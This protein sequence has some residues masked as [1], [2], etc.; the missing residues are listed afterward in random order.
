MSNYKQCH[1]GDI[2]ATDPNYVCNPSTGRWIKKNG[3]VHKTLINK[4]IINEDG[5]IIEKTKKSKTKP[6]VP[7]KSIVEKEKST[8]ASKKKTTTVSK[9]KVQSKVNKTGQTMIEKKIK[10]G[11]VDFNFKECAGKQKSNEICDPITGDWIKKCGSKYQSLIEDGIINKKGKI[12]VSKS[13]DQ[14]NIEKISPILESE[15]IENKMSDLVKYTYPIYFTY[16]PLVE[17]KM[18]PSQIN[19]QSIINW[20]QN[21]FVRINLL[22]QTTISIFGDY[23]PKGLNVL[24]KEKIFDSPYKIDY[25]EYIGKIL[26]PVYLQEMENKGIDKESTEGDNLKILVKAA[27]GFLPANRQDYLMILHKLFPQ[28][29]IIKQPDIGNCYYCAIGS[30]LGAEE[31]DVRKD[32]VSILKN[33]DD[34]TYSDFLSDAMKDCP[35]NSNFKKRYLE[36]KSQFAEDYIELMLKSCEKGMIDCYD[37]IWGGNYFDTILSGFYNRPIL[38]IGVGTD[39][40]VEAKTYQLQLGEQFGHS[41]SL[42]QAV[43]KLEMLEEESDVFDDDHSPVSPINDSPVSPTNTVNREIILSE[44][45]MVVVMYYSIPIPYKYDDEKNSYLNEYQGPFISYVLNMG[46][47]HIDAI[48]FDQS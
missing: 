11:K 10:S 34:D 6:M 30:N 22:D 40:S 20:L 9:K 47:A 28:A 18:D 39:Q 26:I 45:P 7:K 1:A 8:T 31:I 42:L 35:E 43:Q 24:E 12:I 48:N 15:K 29:K 16:R 46:R 23:F 4:R 32:I 44:S 5:E 21:D 17:T 25:T 37:C 41:Q 36:N 3:A 14:I 13:N 33:M 19:I 38:A 27:L 2:K